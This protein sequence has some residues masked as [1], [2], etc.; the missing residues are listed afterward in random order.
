MLELRAVPGLGV[1]TV[2]L[3]YL[4]YGIDS[5]RALRAALESGALAEIPGFGKKTLAGIR[6]YLAEHPG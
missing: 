2:R 1:K 6:A 4:A 5:L 3:L